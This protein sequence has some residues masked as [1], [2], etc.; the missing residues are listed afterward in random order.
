MP[1]SSAVGLSA[2]FVLWLSILGL[3]SAA[4][5][6]VVQ[7]NIVFM[8]TSTD[9]IEP[10]LTF[11]DL[12]TLFLE[13]PV[14]STPSGRPTSIDTSYYAEEDISYTTL[15][16]PGSNVPS[17]QLATLTASTDDTFATTSP[18]TEFY[19]DTVYT[20]PTSCPHPFTFTTTSLLFVP[21]GAETNL[22]PTSL[23]TTTSL[24][25]DV[26]VT[27]YLSAGAVNVTSTA[28]SSDFIQSEY[29]ASCTNPATFLSAGSYPTGYSYNPG[30]HSGGDDG[31]YN[32]YGYRYGCLGS[33]C[34]FWLI[35]I[36]VIIPI[37]V[38]LFLGGLI[39]SYYWF[40]RLMKG[41]SALRGVPIMWVAIS[42]WTLCCMRRHRAA[43][44]E[45]Q[46]QLLK[47]WRDMSSGQHISLWL[48][49]G[50][51]HRDPPQLTEVVG[52]QAVV[53]VW[54]SYPQSPYGGPPGGV[55]GPPPPM[56]GPMGPQNPQQWQGAPGWVPQNGYSPYQNKSPY[57]PPP[58]SPPPQM[59]GYTYLQPQQ[60]QMQPM[61]Q[62][63]P[64]PMPGQS[65]E[66]YRGSFV[67]SP[68]TSPSN[69]AAQ[70]VSPGVSATPPPGQTHAPPSE[71]QPPMPG[72]SATPE[73]QQ[74]VPI[75]PQQHVEAPAHAMSGPSSGS[76]AAQ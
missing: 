54:Q 57:S 2:L 64:G 3:T 32:Y 66:S 23:T 76:G 53:P 35:Y 47:Q 50:F 65:A 24:D 20:A 69:V 16:I 67:P 9:D 72:H 48:S 75:A 22:K 52:R 19:I 18:I 31:D 36:V 14:T 17:S 15:Y 46:A 21:H 51:R 13:P 4:Q 11:T 45:A 5:W 27:G 29:I 59:Q 30:L 1:S 43:S 25:G 74:P 39:E 42:L 56:G 62:M 26:Y 73:L 33:L 41:Q 44:P 55:M 38:A 28:T 58:G 60:Q 6:T 40:T 70:P 61:Q 71:Q 12:T 68:G 10:T 63:Q 34:P 8:T 49:Y 7:Y 37:L